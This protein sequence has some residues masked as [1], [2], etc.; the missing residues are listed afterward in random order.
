MGR[1]RVPEGR[2]CSIRSI[3]EGI[4]GPIDSRDTWEYTI[5]GNKRPW[6]NRVP[7]S[8]GGGQ[9]VFELVLGLMGIAMGCC[10]DKGAEARS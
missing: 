2:N 6:R 8:Q 5:L 4:N 1:I 10:I 9:F 3:S 7:F